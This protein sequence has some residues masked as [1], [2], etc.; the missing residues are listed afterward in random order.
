MIPPT[1][2]NNPTNNPAKMYDQNDV[3]DPASYS[4]Q[5]SAPPGTSLRMRKKKENL[6]DYSEH[7]TMHGISY[8][9]EKDIVIVSK[10][11]WL[12]TCLGLGALAGYWI[13]GERG[14]KKLHFTVNKYQILSVVTVRNRDEKQRKKEEKLAQF[15]IL[16]NVSQR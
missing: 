2:T 5:K 4:P 12:L 16:Q 15:D 3:P 9:F 7:A 8:V 10:I 14:E 6:S 13:V 11:F 1:V